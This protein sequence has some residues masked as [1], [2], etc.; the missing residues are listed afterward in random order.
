[1]NFQATRLTLVTSVTLFAASALAHPAIRDQ[2]TRID[3]DDRSVEG[4]IDAPKSEGPHPFLVIAADSEGTAKDPDYKKLANAAVADGWVTLRLDWSYK[5]AK[6][7][8]SADAKKEAEELG[9]VV[10]SMIGSRMMKQFEIDPAKTA[11]VAKGFGAKVAMVPDSDGM[12]D[13]IKAALLLN[14]VCESAEGS[15]AK[16]YAPFLAA[17]TPRMIVAAKDGS[18]ALP[19]VYAAAKDFG[20]SVSLY[21]YAP[22]GADA[23]LPAVNGWIRSLGWSTKP[24]L[25]RKKPDAKKHAHDAQTAGTHP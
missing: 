8:P 2:R 21:T 19:Q 14:P 5:K 9:A 1:M 24:V 3:L 20:D 22:E 17:K 6:G 11:L 15:F 7:A 10:G 25:A 18:C 16:T 4:W 23:V 12:S 13:K